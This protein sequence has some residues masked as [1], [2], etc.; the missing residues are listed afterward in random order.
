MARMH[1]HTHLLAISV[2]ALGFYV[3]FGV[4]DRLFEWT[5]YSQGVSWVFLPSGLRLAL[6]LL[7]GG[8]GAIGVMVGTFWWGLD[9]PVPLAIN[10]AAAVISGGAPWL[11]YWICKR[12]LQIQPSLGNL[13]AARLMQMALIFSL[14]S[15][16]L[17]QAL[18]VPTGLSASFIKGSAVMAIGD[19]MGCLAV[20]YGLKIFLSLKARRA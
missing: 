13:T 1:L 20:L 4:H 2:S 5:Q 19:F 12:S 7:F 17:H 11:A 10:A 3:L 8:S 14:I 6:V 15:A 18:Y 16:L 9:E